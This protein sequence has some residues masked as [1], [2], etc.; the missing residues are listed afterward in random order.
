[1]RNLWVAAFVVA[2]TFAVGASLAGTD[3]LVSQLKDGDPREREEA[4]FELGKLGPAGAPAIPALRQALGDESGSVRN[5]AVHALGE[6]GAKEA[7][8]DLIARLQDEDPRVRYAAA[9]ALGQIG[10]SAATTIPPLVNLLADDHYFVRAEAAR[11]LAKYGAAAVPA[12][13][14]ALEDRNP[15]IRHGAAESLGVIGAAARPAMPALIRALGSGDM[16][17]AQAAFTA[18]GLIGPR[19]ED[20][21]QAIPILRKGLQNQRPGARYNCAWALGQIGNRQLLGADREAIAGEVAALLSD[22]DPIVR[23]HAAESL[24]W[25]GPTAATIPGLT[26][27]LV[28]EN[29]RVRRHAADALGAAGPAAKKALPALRKLADDSEPVVAAAAQAAIRKIEKQ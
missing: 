14:K 21:A 18:I 9:I 28:D 12:L 29:P 5:A 7:T 22:K 24:Q 11:T 26:R 1:M 19:P 23:W 10:G 25:I 8:G 3:E 20:A 27:A 13:E 17:L 2:A 4:A 6:L 15:E 16:D